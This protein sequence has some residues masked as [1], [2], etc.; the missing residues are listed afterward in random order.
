MKMINT[1]NKIVK[2]KNDLNKI[3]VINFR[4]ISSN[5]FKN[6]VEYDLVSSKL[7]TD[8]DYFYYSFLFENLND[9]LIPFIKII[10]KIRH[11]NS[12]QILSDNLVNYFY[13]NWNK[14]NEV[15]T[16]L[17]CKVRGYEVTEGAIQQ[18]YFDLSIYLPNNIRIESILKQ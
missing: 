9:N 7:L 13:Y 11:L 18:C 2:N 5:Y 15:V 16:Y 4:K 14:F 17:N 1:K 12:E 6:N 3:P 8:N 10:P